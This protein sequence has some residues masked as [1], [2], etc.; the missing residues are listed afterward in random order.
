MP[1]ARILVSAW[2]CRAAAPDGEEG[3]LS[4]AL[5]HVGAGRILL[6]ADTSAIRQPARELIETMFARNLSARFGP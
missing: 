2:S 4:P 6:G 5:A 1:G 3:I